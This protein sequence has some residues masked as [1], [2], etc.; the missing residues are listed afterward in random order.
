[1]HMWLFD[2]SFLSAVAF[3][4]SLGV[5]AGSVRHRQGTS[6]QRCAKDV[7]AS[8]H[9]RCGDSMRLG[10]LMCVRCRGQAMRVCSFL[11][12]SPFSTVSTAG[13]GSVL[14]SQNTLV[15]SCQADRGALRRV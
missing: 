11:R 15:I 6:M 12:P 3:L 14:R 1:M 7:C 13:L 8:R 2:G 5:R 4:D 10:D 9:L